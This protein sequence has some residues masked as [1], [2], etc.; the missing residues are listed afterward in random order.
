[1]G[2]A[3]AGRRPARLPSSDPARCRPAVARSAEP[4]G[5]G[6]G[7][8]RSRRSPAGEGH[9]LAD[10]ASRG[11]RAS[12]AAT[13]L[14][15][16]APHA[17]SPRRRLAQRRRASRCGLRHLQVSPGGPLRRR[18]SG[19][20]RARRAGSSRAGT[21]LASGARWSRTP[22]R[23]RARRCRRAPW[24]ARREPAARRRRRP[25]AKARRGDTPYVR[26]AD[27]PVDRPGHT[28][29]AVF[30]ASP[31]WTSIDVRVRFR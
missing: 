30:P 8:P 24:L 22:T 18:R 26:A 17:A 20:A 16:L 23:R 10:G 21:G 9:V 5:R 4:R 19:H 1:M 14:D 12:H 11:S 27:R 25:P 6:T 13:A 2:C 28:G 15:P 3:A 29:S 31:P 7:D